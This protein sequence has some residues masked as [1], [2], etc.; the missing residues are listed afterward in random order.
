MSQN[1]TVICRRSAAAVD[2]RLSLVDSTAG[3]DAAS[4]HSLTIATNSW[5]R[6]PT[7][8]TPSSLRSSAV[9][10]NN[11][12]ALTSFSRNVAS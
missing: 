9:R 5:R 1:S 8:A 7:A 12:S 3:G 2:A 6:W 11:T 10:W 4:S